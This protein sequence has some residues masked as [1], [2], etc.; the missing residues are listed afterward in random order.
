MNSTDFRF[1]ELNESKVTEEVIRQFNCGNDD[2]TQYLHKQ[3]K[4][5]TIQGEGVTYVLVNEDRKCIYAYATIKAHGLYYYEDAEKYHTKQMDKNGQVLLSMPSVEIKMFAIS[6]KLKRQ[7]AYTLD[8][9]KLQHYS[10]IFFKWFL[11][12][13]YYMS[14]NIIGFRMIFLRANNEGETLYRKNGF[15]EYDR[16]LSTYDAKAEGCIP[17]AIA[18]TEIEDVIF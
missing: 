13:L 18:L 4:I 5:D 12:E 6:K 16:Y 9:E 17:L 8:P 11:E 2:M 10:T 7:V 1:I 3:A 14:M 15:I